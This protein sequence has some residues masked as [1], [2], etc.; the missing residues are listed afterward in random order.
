MGILF[1]SRKNKIRK[2]YIALLHVL[3]LALPEP[4]SLK[5]NCF[6]KESS[7]LFMAVKVW[8]REFSMLS[9]RRSR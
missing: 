4:E 3:E 1:F 6:Q 7:G 2:R 8:L 9:M 5:A